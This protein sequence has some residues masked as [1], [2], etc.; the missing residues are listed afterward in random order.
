MKKVFG[1]ASTLILTLILVFGLSSCGECK[2]EDITSSV[3][4]PT[5]TDK[6]YT[7][8]TCLEC[9][10]SYV[11]NYV[12]ALGHTLVT[13]PRVDPTFTE[14]GLTEGS[15]CGV[16]GF[17][18]VAQE[19]IPV[20]PSK[21]NILSEQLIVNGTSI[22]GR[23]SYATTEFNFTNDISV[24]N[25]GAWS[26][27]TDV[28]G[29]HT[30][31]KNATL[32]EG[33]NIFYIH[34][35]NPDKTVTIYTVNI[36]RNHMY[37]VSFDTDGGTSVESQYVEEG[38]L[39]T[40]HSTNK[41]GY[42]FASWNYDFN[43]PITSNI[44]IKA[45]WTANTGTAYKVEYYLENVDKNGYGEPIIENFT[46]TTDTTATAEQKTF[47]HF[48][49]DTSKSTLRGNINGD[50]NLVLK[51]YYTR[52][53][54]TLSNAN[55]TYGS[56][57]NSGSYAY[58]SE[59]EVTATVS[60]L[61]YE[62]LGWYSGEELLSTEIEYT[63]NIDQNVIAKFDIAEEMQNFH[64]TSSA[65]NCSITGII[66]KSVTEIVVPDFVTSINES[67]FYGCSRLENI[68]VPF[69]GLGKNAS[70][71]KSHFGY[72][73]GY[74]ISSS[75]SSSYHYYDDVEQYY[76]TYYIPTSLKTVIITGGTSIGKGAFYNCRSLTSVTILDSVTSI[77]ER[78]FYNC[79]SLTSVTIPDSVTSIGSSAFYNCNSLTS[80][81]ITDIAKW[82]G[83]SFNSSYANP[84]AYAHNLYLNG[85]LVTE[86]EIADSVTSI[87]NY[88]FYNCRSLTSVTI[89]DSVTSIGSYAFSRCTSLT[90]ITVN[91]N[92]QHYKDIDGNLY[93]KDGKILIQYAIGK[94]DTSFTIP[95][96]VTSIGDYAFYGCTSLTS[97]TI[98]NSVESIGDYAFRDCSSLTSV[99]IPDSV[100]SIG[101]Y[102]FYNCDSLK[103]VTIPDSVTSIGNYAFAH[104]SSLSSIKYRGTQTQWKAISKGV[105]WNYSTGN[106]TIIYNYEGE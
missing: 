86:L 64:F 11:D 39:A 72:I 33:N 10:H 26:L 58:G 66:D 67:A 69:V 47:A 19:V 52:N 102:T 8:Y 41:T 90:S 74:S 54:Y 61:G 103:S 97:I 36:Y 46:G 12:D 13:D 99:T 63:F 79:D 101:N 48:T 57:S 34:V 31:N 53:T 20:K 29:A 77:G 49:L 23:F 59:I 100:T 38:Y 81:Y 43:T 95:N 3:T 16:C 25:S 85:E 40:A 35:E 65:T 56:I 92:N 24:T 18:I 83:I 9:G 94:T 2:H 70:G 60:K 71:Y 80:V 73:F 21:S 106:Y 55:I 87:G 76:Y 78:A 88:A 75:S 1:I 37:T 104:C 89:P 91:T 28:N 32:G 68:T 27:S 50:G 44:T 15:H 45:N 42:T 17:V 105:D 96:S 6:G 30:V 14:T 4:Y 5:C 51:V 62:F 7:T 82:C 22:S 84:L 93:S 98:G